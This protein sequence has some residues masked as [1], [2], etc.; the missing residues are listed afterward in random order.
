MAAY[1]FGRADADGGE[2]GKAFATQVGAV[3]DLLGITM[4]DGSKVRAFFDLEDEVDSRLGINSIWANVGQAERVDR[5][6]NCL[7]EMDK[8][9]QELTGIYTS[10]GWFDQV[11]P[12][13]DWSGR[14]LWIA[15]PGASRPRTCGQWPKVSVW[16][17]SW[18]GSVA[19]IRSGLDLDVLV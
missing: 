17:Y 19:A 11:F 18:Q 7:G 3:V 10:P 6:S 15:E 12:G 9:Y 4:T 8:A 1:H 13:A 2:Q 16:Q 5:V 14:K